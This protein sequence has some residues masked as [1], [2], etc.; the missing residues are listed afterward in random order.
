MIKYKPNLTKEDFLL[1]IFHDLQYAMNKHEFIHQFCMNIFKKEINIPVNLKYEPYDKVTEYPF[2]EFLFK[3]YHEQ[4]LD[5][6]VN[7][8]AQ[9]KNHLM[10]F[11]IIYPDMIDDYF[12]EERLPVFLESIILK[13]YPSL[14]DCNKTKLI[15]KF[16]YNRYYFR[17]FNEEKCCDYIQFKK[18]EFIGFNPSD[19]YD[20]IFDMLQ[21]KTKMN[22]F[23]LTKILN[24][25]L[26]KFQDVFQIK[27]PDIYFKCDE[28]VQKVIEYSFIIKAN[29]VRF[30]ID[31]NHYM[32]VFANIEY[33]VEHF[34]EKH[35]PDSTLHF[36]YLEEN[37][38]TKINVYT[39]DDLK[40]LQDFKLFLINN[41]QSQPSVW[42]DRNLIYPILEQYDIEMVLD[43]QNEDKK[44]KVKI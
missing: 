24:K 13:E 7:K 43:L 29:D 42:L 21:K 3:A 22:D 9:F 35:T 39:E 15:D 32:N 31:S 10:H 4:K 37:L 16:L 30:A 23:E 11:F 1:L 36:I 19:N 2:K 26:V 34:V 38:K 17:D 6:P 33:A 41:F 5:L 27:Y 44:L 28:E 20:I 12:K 25:T 18:N 8:Y 40:K 14:E